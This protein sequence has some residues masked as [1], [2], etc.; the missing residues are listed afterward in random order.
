MLH[1]EELPATHDGGFVGSGGF[2]CWSFGFRIC[3][4]F[5]DWDF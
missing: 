5:R 1:G 4:G 2:L 3:L